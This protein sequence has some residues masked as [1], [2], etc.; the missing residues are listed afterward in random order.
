MAC[1]KQSTLR[2]TRSTQW[3]RLLSLSWSGRVLCPLPT[4]HFGCIHLVET[5]LFD[6]W[7]VPSSGK[8]LIASM[9]WHFTSYMTKF[10]L[11]SLVRLIHLRSAVWGTRLSNQRAWTLS[12]EKLE[13]TIHS[14]Q[15]LLKILL[16]NPTF[17]HIS[18]IN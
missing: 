7:K 15:I 2:T 3:A 1:L 6:L 5:R 17:H 12:L 16:S 8:L 10:V 9:K 13:S 14:C 11:Y 4:P 18:N